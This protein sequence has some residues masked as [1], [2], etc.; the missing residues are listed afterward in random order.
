MRR[1]DPDRFGCVT[2]SPPRWETLSLWLVAQNSHNP[3]L[4][5]YK[6]WQCGLSPAQ[7]LSSSA[8]QGGRGGRIMSTFPRGQ[9]CCL[10]VAFFK[11]SQALHFHTL[12]QCSPSRALIQLGTSICNFIPLITLSTKG[13][14]TISPI[15]SSCIPWDICLRRIRFKSKDNPLIRWYEMNSVVCNTTDAKNTFRCV[16]EWRQAEHQNASSVHWF[17][18]L[19]TELPV[20]G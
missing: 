9:H 20:L 4:T 8:R 14:A 7:L 10:L 12:D 17:Q 15:P 1:S 2:H 3:C 5:Q 6:W 16:F 18:L 19:D 13:H 11:V